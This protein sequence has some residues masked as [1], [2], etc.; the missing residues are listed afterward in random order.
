M[1]LLCQVSTPGLAATPQTLRAQLH[2]LQQQEEEA[3]R[4]RARLVGKVDLLREETAALRGLDQERRQ[5]EEQVR[6]TSI[7]AAAWATWFCV[8]LAY[9]Y[10]ASDICMCHM[11]AGVAL[12]NIIHCSWL[13]AWP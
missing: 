10:W 3:E 7:L 1:S 11:P 12:R 6:T 4:M 9:H 5:L 13:V 2:K 8:W